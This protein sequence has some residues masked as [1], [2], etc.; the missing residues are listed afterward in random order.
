MGCEDLVAHLEG[1]HGVAP[2]IADDGRR[3][4]SR[5][6][7]ASAI[8]RSRP[9]RCSTAS[10]SAGSI[11]N[12]STPSS[13][14]LKR[15]A[16]SERARL[17]PR[18]F[19]RAVGRRRSGRAATF[20]EARA[21]ASTSTIVR[22]GSRGLFW[23][24][25]LVEVETRARPPRLWADRAGGGR[26]AVRRRVPRRRRAPQGARARRGDPLSREPA[27]PALRALRRDRSAV[28]RGLSSP[29]RPQGARARA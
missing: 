17:R 27:A 22:N 5:R 13:S 1:R 3:F 7:I 29:R 25:P 19:L 15:R 14:A 9:P 28:A 11:A 2:T 8:A 6:S 4:T 26:L 16:A 10:R 20:D 18:R 24:E 23:L 12:A 21:A